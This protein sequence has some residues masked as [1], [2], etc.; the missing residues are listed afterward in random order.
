MKIYI[1]KKYGFFE[2][3]NQN[4]GMLIRSNV[5]DTGKDPEIRSFPEL[6]DIGIMGSCSAGRNGI[7]RRA[8][9]DCYQRGMLSKR[10]DMSV[11]AYEWILT[12]CTGK[13]FQIALGGA[14]DPNKHYAF[15]TLLEKTR[16]YDIVPNLTTSGH[17]LTNNEINLINKYCGAVAVSFY[18]RLVDGKED[19][20]QTICAI[21]RLVE[22]GCLTN[23]HYVISTD[24]IDDAIERFEKNIWPRGINAIVFLLYKPVGLGIEN[25]MITNDDKLKRFLTCAT[26]THFPFRVGFDT[27]FT[28]ALCD[29]DTVDLKSIDACEAAKF[30]MYID[31]ELTA[32]PC[33]FSIDNRE[34][35]TKL[36]PV[37]IL[38]VWNGNIFKSIRERKNVRC[39]QCLHKNE[40]R[41]GCGIGLPIELC[42]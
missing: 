30:S 22:A 17:L 19:N 5:E 38:D 10:Q 11:D 29:I 40:C 20:P 26:S 42:K 23:I 36:N 27:C 4:N 18:S 25:K 41:G 24:S 28:S 6:L 15:Q 7:C 35:G 34:M 32:Y 8:G 12:Q 14:G 21:E 33:S 9:V 3:F 2:L 13:V 1:D 16:E 37:T 31:S 39:M